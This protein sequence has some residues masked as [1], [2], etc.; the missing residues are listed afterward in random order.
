M[1]ENRC[2]KCLCDTC[3]YKKTDECKEECKECFDTHFNCITTYCPK[4]EADYG[5]A[6]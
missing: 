1:A 6:R 2:D 4:W 3:K 5:K